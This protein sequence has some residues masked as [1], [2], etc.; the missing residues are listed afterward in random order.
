M[1]KSVILS[2][3]VALSL[4]ATAPQVLAE[5]LPSSGDWRQTVYLYGMGVSLDG[6]AQVGPLQVPVDVGMSDF[7]DA[8]KFGAMAAYQIQNNGWSFAGDMAYMN[9]GSSQSTQQGR[10]GA[11]LDVEQFTLMATV[12]KRV[13]P[14]LE[15]LLSL[16]YVDVSAD[17]RVRVL[18]QVLTANRSADWVDPLMGL[19]YEGSLHDKW[20]Y[21]LRG[22][23]GGFGFGSDLSWNALARLNYR[24]SE[25]IAW[26]I[27]YR[28]LAYD[29][30]EGQGTNYQHYDLVQHGPGL[31]VAFSF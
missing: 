5:D 17:L 22:D 18:Q 12:G 9:L 7:F 4:G 19:K 11:G 6:D 21:T 15:A 10:A 30:T 20:S 23:I 2:S 25:Q 28:A 29:Y 8:L 16:M 31:G 13:S 14:N 26:Y 1:M 27:G 24:Q 3:V